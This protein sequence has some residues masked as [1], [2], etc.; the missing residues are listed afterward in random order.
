M[1]IHDIIIYNILFKQYSSSSNNHPFNHNIYTMYSEQHQLKSKKKS[2]SISD[3][4]QNGR[5]II[6]N[7]DDVIPDD[8]IIIDGNANTTNNALFYDENEANDQRTKCMTRL[9]AFIAGIFHGVAGPGG[10]LGV[11]V[12]LK[13]NDWFLSSLYLILFFLSS[14]IT[15]G[16]YAIT[17]GY[18]TQR[19]TICANNKQKCAFILKI[20]SATFSLIVGVLWLS[21]T[22]TGT[23]ED[24]FD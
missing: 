5:I 17:Y 9:V 10:V 18:C 21:L 6:N 13:L 3:S 7:K 12:A 15:M 2:I 1:Y 22:F 16:I 4:Y 23:L 24:L 11:M 8:D 14:I 19:M 20:V